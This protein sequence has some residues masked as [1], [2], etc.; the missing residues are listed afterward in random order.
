M[1]FEWTAGLSSAFAASTLLK[2]VLA[3]LTHLRLGWRVH[4]HV[5]CDLRRKHA[6]FQTSVQ[7]LLNRCGPHC[8]AHRAGGA[9]RGD[10]QLR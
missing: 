4:S 9:L 7:L 2:V 5:S 8:F 3:W 6:G 10:S 1:P